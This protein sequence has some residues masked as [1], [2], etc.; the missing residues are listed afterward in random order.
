M[1]RSLPIL[2]F[3]KPELSS[4]CRRLLASSINAYFFPQN[5]TDALNRFRVMLTSEHSR[6]TYS[7]PGSVLDPGDAAVRGTGRDLLWT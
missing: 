7:M 5:H 6:S 3:H 1:P 4:V 2:R